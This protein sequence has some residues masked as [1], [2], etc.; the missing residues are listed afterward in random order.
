MSNTTESLPIIL[1][2]VTYLE[3]C[4]NPN[5]QI[6]DLGKFKMQYQESPNVAEYLDIYRAVGRDYI[7]NYRPGQSIQEIEQL[8]K[9]IDSR[10]CYLYL[11]DRIVGLAE[12]DVSN[13]RDVELVHFGL[14][15]EFLNQGIGKLF[16]NNIIYEVWNSGVDRMW[17]STCSLDHPKAIRFYQSAGFNIFKTRMGE[18]K[19]YRFSDFYDLNDAPH[20][21]Y[22]TNPK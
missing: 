13:R 4:I 17:L 18:F 12:L 8:L 15:P 6:T 3:M 10:L 19:D 9:S 14:I 7:W 22:G 11:N 1:S 5:L 16:L 21:P 2:E 20:I